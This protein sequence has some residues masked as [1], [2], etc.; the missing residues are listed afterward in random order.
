MYG[1]KLEVKSYNFWSKAFL[2]NISH[3][4]ENCNYD[5]KCF[6]LFKILFDFNSRTSS[7]KLTG[8]FDANATKY[9][10]II[11]NATDA[12]KVVRDKFETHKKCIE[13]LA[14]GTNN[15]ESQLPAAGGNGQVK[16]SPI[17]DKLKELCETVDTL[18]AERQVIES[19]IKG[20]NPDMKQVFLNAN[21]KGPINEAEMSTDTLNVAFKSL[22]EQVR[23][24]I[25]IRVV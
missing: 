10:T 11:N 12:D 19:E 22:I 17:V 21:K 15:M 16:D 6:Q 7:D 2:S 1:F 20:S 23:F 5:Q 8:T 13:M 24:F 18:K 3:I 4:K 9:R 14:K 25:G